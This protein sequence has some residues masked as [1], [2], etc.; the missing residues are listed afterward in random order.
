MCD[1]GYTLAK[2]IYEDSPEKPLAAEI[3]QDT[4]YQAALRAFDNASNPNRSRGGLKKC[5]EM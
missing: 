5:D 1:I 4:V 3:I 2:S